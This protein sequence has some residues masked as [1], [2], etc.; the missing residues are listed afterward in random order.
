MQD[1]AE[2]TKQMG[3]AGQVRG[4][5][6][7]AQGGGGAP[8]GG[9]FASMMGGGGGSLGYD[10]QAGMMGQGQAGIAQ[11]GGLMGQNA[12]MNANQQ[13]AQDFPIGDEMARKKRQMAMQ[14]FGMR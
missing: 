11:Q 13:Q 1:Q 4:S 8:G 10:Q 5:W 9:G 3:Q 14:G 6:K 7:D 12:A 2:R